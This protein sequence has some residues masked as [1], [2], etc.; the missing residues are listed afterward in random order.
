M[1]STP[2]TSFRIDGSDKSVGISIPVSASAPNSHFMKPALRW[3]QIL[4]ANWLKPS[5]MA[6]SRLL[7][8]P[9]GSAII[10]LMASAPLL[11]DGHQFVFELDDRLDDRDQFLHERRRP[12]LCLRPES[13]SASLALLKPSLYFFASCSASCCFLS[14]M[15]CSNSSKRSV[16]SFCALFL[17]P[18]VLWAGWQRRS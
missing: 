9:I 10:S 17:P 3:V 4:L 13:F 11:Q 14:S 5:L 8:K 15:V 18:A 6:S 12:G 1:P 16:T 7:R 2:S